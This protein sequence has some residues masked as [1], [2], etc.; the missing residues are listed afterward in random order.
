M[1]GAKRNVKTRYVWATA[2][3]ALFVVGC[4]ST[5]GHRA[6]A[7][8]TAAPTTVD[9]PTTSAPPTTADPPPAKVVVKPRVLPD[10]PAKPATVT[11]Q[12]GDTLTAISERTHRTVAQFVGWNHLGDPDLILTG[13]V[14]KVPP[15][16]YNA[17]PLVYTAPTP[18]PVVHT[19][20]APVQAVH[21]VSTYQAPVRSY[22]PPSPSY[23][24]GGGFQ[25]CVAWRESTDGAG[26]SN[27]YGI[28][29][30]TWSSLGLPGSAYTASRAQQDAAFQELYARDGAAPWAP[31]DGC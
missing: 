29:N 2:T 23:S 27:I 3:V 22:S 8:T 17:P 1:L 30:S 19:N 14:F 31:Y 9:P 28:L 15:A 21:A 24:P 4:S 7:P 13:Q 25:S 5:Q 10:P 18:A 20:P 12:T 16:S 11:V 6:S 26:S